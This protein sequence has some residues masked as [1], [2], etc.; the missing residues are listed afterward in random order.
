MTH[1]QLADEL[2]SVREIVTRLLR[3][4]ADQ[5]LVRLTRGAVEVLDA[6]ALRRV[7]EGD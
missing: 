5:G 7:A 6:A 3:G 4:F 2:G 1:Q